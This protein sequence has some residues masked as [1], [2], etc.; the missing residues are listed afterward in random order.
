MNPIIWQLILNLIILTF[1]PAKTAKAYEKI[2]MKKKN[3]STLRYYTIQQTEKLRKK[4][5]TKRIEID[6]AMRYGN[7]AIKE[8][9]K[10]M[11]EKGCQEIIVFLYSLN[12]ATTATVCDEVNRSLMS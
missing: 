5:K 1:R 11:Q 4:I 8:K 10:E 6:Y 2:W 12:T 3:I 9:M 7:P